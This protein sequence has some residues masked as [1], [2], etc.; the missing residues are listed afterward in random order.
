MAITP[1]LTEAKAREGELV[2]ALHAALQNY[3]RA[4]FDRSARYPASREEG[5]RRAADAEGLGERLAEALWLYGR[6]SGPDAMDVMAMAAEAIDDDR[7][8]II[9]ASGRLWLHRRRH[10]RS[11]R[12][13]RLAAELEAV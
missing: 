5:E 3:E 8:A 13:A 9:T 2:K 6:A 11:F 12:Q 4:W 1:E 7:C 10:E